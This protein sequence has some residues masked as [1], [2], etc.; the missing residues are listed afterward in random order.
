MR[1]T[2]MLPQDPRFN[3]Y[4]PINADNFNVTVGK[5][6]ENYS[7]VI[8]DIISISAESFINIHNASPPEIGTVVIVKQKN[9][10]VSIIL[11]IIFKG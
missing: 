4:E 11:F 1:I 3:N 7:E 10:E 5:S 6:F 2:S 9:K 8:S